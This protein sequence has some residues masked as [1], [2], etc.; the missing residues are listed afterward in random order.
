MSSGLSTYGV[1]DVGPGATV[2]QGEN[3]SVGF[4]AAQVQEL[5]RAERDGLVQQ[6]SSQ[7]VEL[8][9]QL[10]ATREAVR[11]MLHIAGHD[12]VP[13]ERQRDTLIAIATQYRAV[14]QTLTRPAN[15]DRETA[16]LRRQAVSALDSGAFD[17]ATHLL[18]DIRVR[19]RAASEQRRCRVEKARGEWLAGLQPEAETCACS[20]ERLWHSATWLV[21]AVTLKTG[22]AC[23]RRSMRRR[24]GRTR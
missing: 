16:E 7:L 21:R 9:A 17:D 10:G 23:W 19:E 14:R 22:C 4:T 5:V 8:S 3:L 1:G 18:N 12:D 6:F 11:T 13:A 20:R 24:V 15:D 2:L